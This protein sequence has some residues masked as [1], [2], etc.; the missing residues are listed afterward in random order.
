M[1]ATPSPSS[2]PPTVASAPQEAGRFVEQVADA[3]LKV[4]KILVE[5]G[6][7]TKLVEDTMDTVGASF[8]G[9]RSCT[10]NVVLTGIT[11]GVS[12]QRTTVTRIAR[13]DSVGHNLW[14]IGQVMALAERCEQ[15]Q[16]EPGD[17]LAQLEAIERGPFHRAPTLALASAVGAVGFAV[18]YGASGAALVFVA[19]AAAVTMGGVGRLLDHLL[20]SP[21]L[22]ILGQAFAAALACALFHR[23]MPGVGIEAMLIPVLMLLVPGMTLT[24]AVLDTMSGSYIS[25]GARLIMTLLV[26]LTIA[27]G[28]TVALHYSGILTWQPS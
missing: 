26:G 24:T 18:F 19:V 4:G 28:A 15:E 17:A 6:C 3:V 22:S 10:A 13:I 16:L 7:E 20:P 14:A 12:T 8:K 5:G 27:V 23:L 25:S 2:T 9:V 1:A 21:Y 11:L